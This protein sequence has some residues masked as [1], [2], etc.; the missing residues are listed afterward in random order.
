MG[1]GAGGRRRYA[2]MNFIITTRDIFTAFTIRLLHTLAHGLPSAEV[3][4][5][6]SL[7]RVTRS[8]LQGELGDLARDVVGAVVATT[9]VP[10]LLEVSRTLRKPLRYHPCTQDLAILLR[11]SLHALCC[12]T[13]T[14]GNCPLLEGIPVAE[15]LPTSAP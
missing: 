10:S 2:L 9:G 11:S 5:I 8:Y 13:G 4:S 15:P 1:S 12:G 14:G 6:V 7:D 3:D